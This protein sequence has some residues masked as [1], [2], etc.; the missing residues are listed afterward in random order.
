MDA[1]DKR[2]L[3]LEAEIRVLERQARERQGK[4]DLEELGRKAMMSR[5]RHGKTRVDC[6]TCDADFI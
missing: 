5:C 4:A 2:I 3:E 6:A 1:K